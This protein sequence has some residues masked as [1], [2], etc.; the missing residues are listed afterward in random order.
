MAQ[1]FRSSDREDR[2]GKTF[3]LLQEQWRG[4]K[5][6]DG[7]T[8]KPKTRAASVLRKMNELSTTP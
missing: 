6:T 7:N 4:Y 1:A 5:N 3:F 2:D 8:K